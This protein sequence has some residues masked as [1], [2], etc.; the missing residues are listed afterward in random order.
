MKIGFYNDHRPCIVKENGVVDIS[1]QIHSSRMIALIFR[2]WKRI[3][4]FTDPFYFHNDHL[5]LLP[6]NAI[7]Y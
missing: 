5:F 2:Q 4:A 3:G 7:T 6:R 1:H